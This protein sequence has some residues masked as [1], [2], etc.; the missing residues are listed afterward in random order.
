M[1][2]L[3]T[4]VYLHEA[5]MLCS[6]LES[7]GIK[8]FIPDQNTV[9]VQPF[10]S[11]AMGGIRIQVDEND[12]EHARE[13]LANALPA[14]N[15]ERDECPKIDSTANSVPWRKRFR[16]EIRI[17]TGL[18]LIGVGLVGILVPVLPGWTPLIF[19]ILMLAPKTRF[20]RWV[21][22]LL[23]KMRRRARQRKTNSTPPDPQNTID[24]KS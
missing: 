8:T 1:I 18:V 5:D 21:R 22:E 3:I 24:S 15:T 16:R 19:G 11:N 10:Y 13:V 23:K 20:S 2:T 9:S 7:S 17:G 14:G 4:V 6:I 12:L